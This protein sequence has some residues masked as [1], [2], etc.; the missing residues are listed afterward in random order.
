LTAERIIQSTPSVEL[1]RFGGGFGSSDA[2]GGEPKD[3]SVKVEDLVATIYDRL[4][5]D[6]KEYHTPNDRPVK[7]PTTAN[8]SA[9][10]C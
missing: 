6:P 7:S 10:L 4:G 1:A 2:L 8:H 9:R 5:I 3:N